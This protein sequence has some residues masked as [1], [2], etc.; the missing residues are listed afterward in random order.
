MEFLVPEQMLQGDA[1]SAPSDEGAIPLY[2]LGC[3][4]TLGMKVHGEAVEPQDGGEQP[5]R[6]RSGALD[7]GAGEGPR[8]FRQRLQP[9]QGRRHACHDTLS[10]SF[11]L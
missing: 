8:R 3:E 11:W 5:F 7:A 10:A 2:V 4:P 1:R 9:T 6:V